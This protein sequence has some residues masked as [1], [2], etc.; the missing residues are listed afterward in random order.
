MTALYTSIKLGRLGGWRWQ[1]TLFRL[2]RQLLFPLLAEGCCN[3]K[4]TGAR[5]EFR[6]V[7]VWLTYTS[8]IRSMAASGSVCSLPWP[9]AHLHLFLFHSYP[10]LPRRPVLNSLEVS[11]P[12]RRSCG[13][14]WERKATRPRDM[15]MRKQWIRD[16]IAGQG[17]DMLPDPQ[18]L[19]FCRLDAWWIS[20]CLPNYPVSKPIVYLLLFYSLLPLCFL[21]L[22]S[23]F[24]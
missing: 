14:C 2:C 19:N 17:E 8:K 21:Y 11:W 12:W 15:G 18:I 1:R 22:F 13:R 7:I 3:V 4:P 5:P 6:S 20:Y 9:V 23:S 24:L 16:V 10:R